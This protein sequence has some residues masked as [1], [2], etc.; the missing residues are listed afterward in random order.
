[1]PTDKIKLIFI[2]NSPENPAGSERTAFLLN[3]HL[4]KSI[5]DIRFILNAEGLFAD[6]LRNAKADVE[7]IS[8]K[9]NS[10]ISWYKKL[11]VS[12]KKKPADVVQLHLSRL[13]APLLHK[14]GCKIIE[15]LN[16]NRHSASWYPMRWKWIDKLTAR[17]VDH[18]IVVSN[19]LKK[20]FLNRGYPA[21]KLTT[22]YN[23]IPPQNTHAAH[24]RQELGLPPASFIVGA[25]GRLTYQKGMDTFIKAA[26]IIHNKLPDCYFLLIG[27]GEERKKL[28]S[29]SK[30]LGIY[31]YCYFLG[32][33]SDVIP[34][35]AELDVLLYLS[36]WEPFA[37][38]ILEAMSV[39]TPIVTT[40]TGGNAEAVIEG[41]NGYKVPVGDYKL[42][43]K[44]CMK[45]LMEPQLKKEL[46]KAQRNR[47]K[48]FSLSKMISTHSKLYINIRSH[49][50]K[51]Q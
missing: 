38:T 17:W 27:D 6:Q 18:F 22:I 19:S 2:C 40:N 24:L 4:D 36:R 42:A 8:S 28:E 11:D 31:K 49:N 23:G 37:N 12:L 13:N 20:E 47:S 41:E 5:F 1:M 35:L 29:L 34:L 43:A 39:G 44:S 48:D 32:H 21:N 14:N 26:Q 3:Q 45:I 46:S 51:S 9:S 30:S 16:M 33:R 15:R 25:V 50:P 10:D 7:V